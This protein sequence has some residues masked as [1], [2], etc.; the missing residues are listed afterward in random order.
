MSNLPISSK[1][2]SQPQLPVSEAERD[3]LTRRLND[4][5]ERG[6]VSQDDYRSLLDQLYS[7]RTLG[8]LVPVV[9]AAAVKQ[10]HNTPA[11]VQDSSTALRPGEVNQT[12]GSLQL[13]KVA[14]VGSMALAGLLVL[15]L[16]IL[17]L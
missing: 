12:A 4:A 17:A 2:R 7:A 8:D 1:Y 16:V 9:E 14:M 10:T 3:D 11:I 6:E 15:L 5:F 13:G